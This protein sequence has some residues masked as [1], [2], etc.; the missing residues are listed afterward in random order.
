MTRRLTVMNEMARPSKISQSPTCAVC[1]SFGPHRSLTKVI[2]RLF[3]DGSGVMA[4]SAQRA[5]GGLVAEVQE[6]VTTSNCKKHC[7]RL[8]T[9]KAVLSER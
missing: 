5:H 1:S 3:G 7:A 9:T 8:I 2:E 6:G 4:Y